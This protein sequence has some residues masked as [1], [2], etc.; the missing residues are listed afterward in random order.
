MRAPTPKFLSLICLV[1]I[2]DSTRLRLD[3]IKALLPSRRVENVNLE[4]AHT[5]GQPWLVVL[6]GLLV[7]QLTED[8]VPRIAP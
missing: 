7:H 5:I 8:R 6:W 1:R 2:I 4:I 3:V